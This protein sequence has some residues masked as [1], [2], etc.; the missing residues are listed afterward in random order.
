MVQVITNSEFEEQVLKAKGV[1]LVDFFAAW[2]GPCQVIAPVLDELA[3]SLED[4]AKI[5]KV[6]V[7]ESAELASKYGVM[8]IPAIKIFKEGVVVDELTGSQSKEALIEIINKN[9]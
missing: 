4:D 5:F 8:S 2:C 3:S 7:D 6:D 9:K 1:V